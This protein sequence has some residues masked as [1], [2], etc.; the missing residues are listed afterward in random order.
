[1]GAGGDPP[2]SE[3]GAVLDGSVGPRSNLVGEP[4]EC[5]YSTE[6]T[7]LGEADTGEPTGNDKTK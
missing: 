1:M 7:V 3:V 4:S 2:A 6:W 5:S